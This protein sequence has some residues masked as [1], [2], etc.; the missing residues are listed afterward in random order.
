MKSFSSILGWL[1][2]VAVLA[3][4]SFLFYNWWSKSRQQA[5]T[6]VTRGPVTTDVF[7]ASVPAAAAPPSAAPQ[8]ARN[9]PAAPVGVSSQTADAPAEPAFKAVPASM[10]P[11]SGEQPAPRPPAAAPL[12]AQA[13]S[14]ARPAAS[15]GPAPRP[16]TGPVLQGPGA[17][18]LSVRT[19]TAPQP[20]SYY[21]PTATRDPTLTPEDYRKIREQE[22]QRLQEERQ[23]R[24]AEIRHRPPGPETLISLQGIV[25][26]AAI[27]NGDMYR[28][29]QTVRGIKILRVGP[30]YVLCE[31]KGKR[32]RK[33]MR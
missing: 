25:G 7:P 18:S 9:A 11:S 22:Y 33:I 24:L 12:V 19:S 27:I 13:V 15:P 6:E 1:L 30:D 10:A 2:L 29:G 28:A 32:F 17:D 31:Y 23:Q 5:S 8:P 3:V 14:A 26:T 4:P 21:A 16:A 20:L